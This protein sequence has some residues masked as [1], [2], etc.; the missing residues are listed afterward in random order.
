MILL[1]I[2]ILYPDKNLL[3]V[4]IQ[5]NSLAGVRNSNSLKMN[6]KRQVYGTKLSRSGG[7]LKS[8]FVSIFQ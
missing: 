7:D 4:S 5:L 2:N 3:A 6:W 1:P 8:V